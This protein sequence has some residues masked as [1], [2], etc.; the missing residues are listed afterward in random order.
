MENFTFIL[1]LKGISKPLIISKNMFIHEYS[2]NIGIQNNFLPKR[3][4]D[5]DREIVRLF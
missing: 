5:S 3:S 2:Q 1:H 4:G